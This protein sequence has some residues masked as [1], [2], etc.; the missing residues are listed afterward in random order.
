MVNT[1]SGTWGNNPPIHSCGQKAT[2]DLTNQEPEQRQ[3]GALGSSYLGCPFR[4]GEEHIS[5]TLCSSS[6]NGCWCFLS[7]PCHLS[8][9]DTLAESWD[10]PCLGIFLGSWFGGSCSSW[11]I[12]KR[13]EVFLFWMYTRIHFLKWLKMRPINHHRLIR[14]NGVWVIGGGGRWKLWHVQEMVC[15][16]ERLPCL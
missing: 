12:N 13:G 15:V 14:W 9:T 16:K 3:V 11:H 8:A 1:I 6:Q 4:D 7:Y 5:Q 10:R 2:L